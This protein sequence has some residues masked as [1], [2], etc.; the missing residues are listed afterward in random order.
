[1]SAVDTGL[2][3]V[4][5]PVI[6]TGDLPGALAFYRD[7]LGFRIDSEMVHDPVPLARLG[8]PAGADA[9]AVILKAPDGSELEIAS[10]AAPKGRPLTDDPW[11]DAGIRSITFVVADIEAM[12]GRMAA[13]GYPAAGEVVRF[14]V[15]GGPV[16]VAYVRGPDGVILTLL[17]RGETT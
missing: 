12:L 2:V 6:I 10:F 13:A 3:G 8:G 17:Q 15:D 14:Q 9:R 1:M 11:P 5:H 4:L 7:L 16:L